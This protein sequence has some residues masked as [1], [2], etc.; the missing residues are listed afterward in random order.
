MPK[1]QL[2]IHA[3]VVGDADS[4]PKR[5]LLRRLSDFGSR[6]LLKSRPPAQ[7]PMMAPR[8]SVTLKAMKKRR[9]SVQAGV[10]DISKVFEKQASI[11]DMTA[12]PALTRQ[13]GPNPEALPPFHIIGP[14]K[15]KT[16][17][18]SLILLHGFTCSGQQ[19]AS[20]LLPWL[21]QRLMPS[22][23][24]GIRFVFLTAPRRRVSCY[25]DPN[26]EENAWHDY[27]SDHGGAEGRPNIE[28]D[29]DVGQLDWTRAQVHKAIDAEAKLLGGDY[30]KVALLG[31]SQGSCT[32]L[33]CALTHPKSI[34]G[35]LCSIG[36]LYSHTPVSE[37]RNDLKVFT[38]NGAADDCIGCSLSLRTY[39]RLLEAGYQLR[40]HIQP[41]VSHEGST[42]VEIDLLCEALESWGLIREGKVRDEVYGHH[43]NLANH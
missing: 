18:A 3:V 33:H 15:G 41:G 37:K 25:D 32:A 36:Q 26:Q 24:G 34:A 39:S 16:H 13:S 35:I 14:S 17:T 10:D 11:V 23:F 1:R 12:P 2:S 4:Q 27:F 28:E 30:K 38:F 21:K 19:L 42:D 6:S 7:D 29:I 8:G 40:M 43:V 22:A 20:E 9:M 31:Q 5:S